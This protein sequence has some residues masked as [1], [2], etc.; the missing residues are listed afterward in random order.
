MIEVNIRA[1]AAS[2]PNFQPDGGKPARREGEYMS[3]AMFSTLESSTATRSR[4]GMAFICGLLAQALMLSAAVIVGEL[5]PQELSL[6]RH[7]VV[8]PYDAGTDADAEAG[9]KATACSAAG[10][11]AETAHFRILLRSPQPTIAALEIP[12]IQH[13]VLPAHYA[14]LEVLPPP[15]LTAQT[16]MPKVQIAVHTGL[17]GGAAEPVSDPTCRCGRDSEQDGLELR[18]PCPRSGTRQQY[19]QCREIGIF[20]VS[21]CE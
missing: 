3:A 8:S 21:C 10:D 16:Q 19:G 4:R 11:R 20:R 2:D 18:K 5:F 7:F 17:F 6:T 14:L 1:T 13:T 15:A 9:R 12:K